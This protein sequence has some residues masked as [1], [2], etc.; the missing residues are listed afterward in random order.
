MSYVD[1][2]H[3]SLCAKV[4]S[5]PRRVLLNASARVQ[6]YGSFGAGFSA[7][8]DVADMPRPGAFPLVF[9]GDLFLNVNLTNTPNASVQVFAPDN[10]NLAAAA[11]IPSLLFSA[12]VA[13]STTSSTVPRPALLVDA[14]PL[15]RTPRSLLRVRLVLDPTHLPVTVP[16]FQ[17]ECCETAMSCLPCLRR[18]APAA[19][20][21]GSRATTRR[22]RCRRSRWSLRK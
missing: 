22:L 21:R 17:V 3:S 13:D 5:S 7:V 9:S 4:H 10:R 20:P 11:W 6:H 15:S 2:L 1:S 19:G 12:L 18:T 16:S 8:P 14:R